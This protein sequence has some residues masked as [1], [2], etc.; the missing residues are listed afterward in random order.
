MFELEEAV[1]G[2]DEQD[3]ERDGATQVRLVTEPYPFTYQYARG[4]V[5]KRA[6]LPAHTH[7]TDAESDTAPF[8]VI[9]R[10]L[11]ELTSGKKNNNRMDPQVLTTVRETLRGIKNG[12]LLKILHDLEYPPSSA[13]ATT[14]DPAPKEA[15]SVALSQQSPSKKKKKG[16]RAPPTP[17]PAKANP[18]SPPQRMNTRRRRTSPAK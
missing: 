7:L 6:F 1:S 10:C 17:P 5:G 12:A 3:D 14:A 9:C 4:I 11:P 18:T 13:K 8:D 15:S 2:S 16:K